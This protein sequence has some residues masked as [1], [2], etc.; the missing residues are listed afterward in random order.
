MYT[1]HGRRRP[2][3]V[4]TGFTAVSIEPSSL[5]KPVYILTGAQHVEKLDDEGQEGKCAPHPHPV[6]S[7]ND[8]PSDKPLENMVAV[9]R[10]ERG[11]RGL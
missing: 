8:Q 11:T 2:R 7:G 4:W 5:R 10:I 3:P 6:E 9:P 1:L